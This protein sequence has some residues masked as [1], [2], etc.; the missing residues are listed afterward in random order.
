MD[1]LIGRQEEKKILANA[2]S[3]PEA[4]LIAVYGRRRVGKTYLIRNVYKERIIFE[5]TGIHEAKLAEQLQNLSLSLQNAMSS[6]VPPA[7]PDNWITAFDF[8]RKYLSTKL[9]SQKSVVFFDEFPWIHTAKSGFLQAFEHFWNAWASRQ[10]N[11]LVVICGS[12]ASWMM[13]N[14]INNRGGLHNRISQQIRLLPFNLGEVET[15]LKS[16]RINL[17]QYQVLQLYMV[18]GGIPHYLKDMKPGESSAQYI[19]RLCFTKDG[20]LKAE[21]KNLYRS[22]FDNAQN[23]EAVIR[24]LAKKRQGLTR[25][26]IMEASGLSSGGTTTKLFSELEESGFISQY[27]P[28]DKDAKDAIYK[29]SDEYSLFYLKFMEGAKSTGAGTWLRQLNG[30][31]FKSWS[32]FAFESICQK[33]IVQIKK[34]LGIEGVH[35]E[36]SAWRYTPKKG[37]AGAQIDMLIDRQDLCINICEMKFST[38][39]FAI[40]K[41]YASELQNKI[42]IFKHSTKTKKALFLTMITTYGVKENAYYAGLLQNEVTAAALFK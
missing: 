19:D 21:F 6:A 22:L 38:A 8:L 26:E 33:H 23:H 32:G 36:V 10:A 30:A 25:N 29:L 27:I 2:L 9:S 5:M 42:N 17:N 41:R 20:I 12:A 31:S 37:E 4:E 35:T 40:D 39:E 11:L 7:I 28:F 34:S 18:M 3:S 1:K 24:A 16:K 13:E 15:Y 14:I